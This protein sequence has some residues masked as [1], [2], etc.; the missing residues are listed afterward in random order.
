LEIIRAQGYAE[1]REEYG[2]DAAAIAF[3]ILGKNGSAIGSL[4]IQS[5]INRITEEAKAHLIKEGLKST[6]KINSI[7][8]ENPLK[9]F[10][11]HSEGPFSPSLPR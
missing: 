1:S 7:L 2:R 8:M 3:P 11:G 4:S 10:F 9:I 6:L 5:T